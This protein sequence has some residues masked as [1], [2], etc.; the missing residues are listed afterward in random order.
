MSATSIV[1]DEGVAA[2][3]SLP[4]L[5][6]C[7]IDRRLNTGVLWTVR[8]VVGFAAAHGAGFMGAFWALR[9][10]ARSIDVFGWDPGATGPTRTV[11]SVPCRDR[12]FCFSVFVFF[13]CN[14]V[15]I[16]QYARGGDWVKAAFGWPLGL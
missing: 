6:L 3:A 2:V 4:A 13:C 14:R 7:E 1:L 5:N 8:S 9:V 15:D 10:L 16:G 11:D 12:P